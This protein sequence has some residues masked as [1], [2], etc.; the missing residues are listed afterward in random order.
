M[1]KYNF[2]N[3]VDFSTSRMSKGKCHAPLP[4]LR[5]FTRNNDASANKLAECDILFKRDQKPDGIKIVSMFLCNEIIS[6]NCS[7]RSF[8]MYTIFQPSVN[9]SL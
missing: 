8:P 4:F 9:C 5:S 1:H 6:K 3:F 2:H 7:K